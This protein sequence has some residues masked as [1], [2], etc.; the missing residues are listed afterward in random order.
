M[1]TPSYTIPGIGAFKDGASWVRAHKVDSAEQ[2]LTSVPQAALE[3]AKNVRDTGRLLST[4]GS[5][6]NDP[7][8]VTI[9]IAGITFSDKT[10]YRSSAVMQCAPSPCRVRCRAL[11]SLTPRFAPSISTSDYVEE[12]YVDPKSAVKKLTKAVHEAMLTV[13]V[14]APDW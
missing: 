2:L 3:Y 7:V 6:P 11:N 12:F 13:T 1:L 14:N 9:C 4:G 8:D 10:K 5:V